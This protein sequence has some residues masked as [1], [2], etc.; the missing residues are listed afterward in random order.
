[1]TIR[2]EITV[3]QVDSALDSQTVKKSKS[4][5]KVFEMFYLLHV[6]RIIVGVLYFPVK[7]LISLIRHMADRV[8]KSMV[9]SFNR[10]LDLLGQK[11]MELMEFFIILCFAY[12]VAI[13]LFSLIFLSLV[14]YWMCKEFFILMGTFNYLDEYSLDRNILTGN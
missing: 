13:G 2:Q 11:L 12:A 6:I 9:R 3:P 4:L 1:M 5:H 14:I 10:R 7:C 8:W